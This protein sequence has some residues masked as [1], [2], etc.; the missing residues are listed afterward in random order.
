MFNID[1]YE[2][3]DGDRPWRWNFSGTDSTYAAHVM[4]VWIRIGARKLREIK[5]CTLA[6]KLAM[7]GQSPECVAIIAKLM[8]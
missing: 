2:K 8:D 6:Y 7:Q 3:D 1:V 4:S 5:D